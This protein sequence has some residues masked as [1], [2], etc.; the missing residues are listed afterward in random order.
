M[1]TILIITADFPYPEIHGG[2][3]DVMNKIRELYR[4]GFLID[5][6]STAKQYPSNIDIIELKKYIR[7][8]QVLIRK[9]SI[10]DFISIKPYQVKNRSKLRKEINSLLF[11]KEYNY[12]LIEGHYVLELSNLF[13]A[14]K[15]KFLR[16]HNNEPRY[17]NQLANSTSNPLKKYYYSFESMK[18]NIYEKTYL[19][20]YNV[21]LLHI[22]KDE[23][24]SYNMKFPGIKQR[25]LPPFCKIGEITRPYVRN[26]KNVLFVGSLFM[27]NNVQ[28]IN[29]YIKNIHPRLTAEYKDYSFIIA[30]KLNKKNKLPFTMS[31][32][33]IFHDSPVDLKEI[34]N[35]SSIF[36]NPM[37]SGAGVKLKTINA[38]VNG[39]PIISTTVGSEGIGLTHEKDI[40]ISDN[41]DDIYKYIKLL[42]STPHMGYSLAIEAQSFL[43][44]NYNYAEHLKLIFGDN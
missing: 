34:Y 26:N 10:F 12:V 16:I 6:I 2:R 29:W 3:V 44:K 20:K 39:I 8:Y 31:R 38:I 17:F 36:I 15:Q 41:P 24:N 27:D 33:I 5:I 9:N 19:T 4:F 43:L 32:N 28:G 30:G 7:N 40:L 25:Y 22:S 1:K 13:I 37:L 21:D 18:F 23:F 35:E 11:N 14:K 42:F